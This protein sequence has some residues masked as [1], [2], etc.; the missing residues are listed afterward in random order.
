[1]DDCVCHETSS[2]GH[3]QLDPGVEYFNTFYSAAPHG[4][5]MERR[6]R[7]RD[8]NDN[9]DEVLDLLRKRAT[10]RICSSASRE[11]IE[12]IRLAHSFIYLIIHSFVPLFYNAL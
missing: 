8:P 2:R 3:A 4:N 5:W 12:S 9:E 7:Q 10:E 1:M 11:R 6:W